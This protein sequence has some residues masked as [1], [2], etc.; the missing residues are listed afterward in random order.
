[1]SDFVQFARAHG[2]VLDHAVADGRWH[3]V[4]TEDKPRKYNGAYLCDGRGGVVRNWATMTDF[5]AWRPSETTRIDPVQFRRVMQDARAEQA[6]K[7]RKAA[8]RAHAMIKSAKLVIPQKTQR[9]RGGWSAAV[10]THPYLVR[11]GFPEQPGLVLGDLLVIPMHDLSGALV[12]AQTI[13]A[14]GKKLFLTGTRAKGAVHRLGRGRELWLVEGYATGLTVQAAAAR[15][16][17]LVEV[18]VCFSAENLRHV[19]SLVEGAYIVADHDASGTGERVAVA[20]GR[21]W[22]M[23]AK[24]GQDANDLHLAEGIDAVVALMREAISRNE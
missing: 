16:Y 6:V 4:K 1:M 9:R 11:K 21:P 7:Q 19:A 17:R 23:P 22:C 14:A 15:L 5:A 20:T 2:L 12:G 8:E 10:A 18:V 24:V 13:D 3:R